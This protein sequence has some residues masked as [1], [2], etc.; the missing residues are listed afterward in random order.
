VGTLDKL[1]DYIA[2][3]SPWAF[4]GA[5]VASAAAATASYWAERKQRKT[6]VRNKTLEI[7]TG[8]SILLEGTGELR[9]VVS[10]DLVGVSIKEQAQTQPTPEPSFPD[11]VREYL[12]NVVIT[13][14][15]AEIVVSAPPPKVI[16]GPPSPETK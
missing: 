10:G 4:L 15:A 9:L 13:P 6:L 7:R 5:V 11:K 8:D 12:G 2:L 16:V 1:I 14:K 3:A